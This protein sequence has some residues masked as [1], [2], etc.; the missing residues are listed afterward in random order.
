[1]Q[2]QPK[3]KVINALEQNLGFA[4]MGIRK[5]SKDSNSQFYASVESGLMIC[6]LIGRKV[7]YLFATSGGGG[8]VKVPKLSSLRPPKMVILKDEQ[9]KYYAKHL[10]AKPAAFLDKT[11]STVMLKWAKAVKLAT[12]GNKKKTSYAVAVVMFKNQDDE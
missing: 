8:E 12:G 1:M 2:I 10:L 11:D 6:E 3:L 5:I 9:K 4:V 7:K